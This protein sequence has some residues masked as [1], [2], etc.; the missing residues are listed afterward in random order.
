[1]CA[2][3]CGRSASV[4]PLT[5]TSDKLDALVE[6]DVHERVESLE[7]PSDLSAPLKLYPDPL[8]Q[9]LLKV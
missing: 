6:D 2:C 9:I 5:H 1:M 4:A 8:V 7:H 3:V